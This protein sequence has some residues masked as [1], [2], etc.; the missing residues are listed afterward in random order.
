MRKFHAALQQ[1]DSHSLFARK[2]ANGLV[3]PIVVIRRFA[4]PMA[5]L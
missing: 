4:D 1:A 2:M 3:V 5:A